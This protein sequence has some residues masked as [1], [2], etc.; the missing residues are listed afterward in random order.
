MEL[1][2]EVC[3]DV[4][5]VIMDL[6]YREIN[7]SWKADILDNILS[8]IGWDIA[9]GIKPDLYKVEDVLS[10]LVDFQE[11]YD[12]DLKKP[13]KKLKKYIKEEEAVV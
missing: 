10:R 6:M 2:H 7:E 9:E 13:I 11:Y 1:L 4:S 3:E 5:N 8:I 12:V